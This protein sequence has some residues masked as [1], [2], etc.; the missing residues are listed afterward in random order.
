[1]LI[2]IIKDWIHVVQPRWGLLITF[3]TFMS[4]IYFMPLIVAIL[5]F[6]YLGI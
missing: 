5:P 1:M 6:T 2:K 3:V 4:F